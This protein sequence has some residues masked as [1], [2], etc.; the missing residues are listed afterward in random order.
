MGKSQEKR[1]GIV[2]IIG[3]GSSKKGTIASFLQTL[4][5]NARNV[6]SIENKGKIGK[7]LGVVTPNIEDI[8]W[9]PLVERKKSKK[10]QSKHLEKIKGKGV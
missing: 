7:E 8:N 6:D 4:E 5:E 1:T 10:K 9:N 2:G 3:E